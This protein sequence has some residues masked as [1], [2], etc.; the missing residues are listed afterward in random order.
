[1]NYLTKK[2][3]DRIYKEI[4]SDINEDIIFKAYKLANCFLS[5]AFRSIFRLPQSYESAE[6]EVYQPGDSPER[7]LW[8]RIN[9]YQAKNL[10]LSISQNE[11][12]AKRFY[13]ESEYELVLLIDVSRSM[14]LKW[15]KIYESNLVKGKIG[16][17]YNNIILPYLKNSKIYTLKLLTT[18]FLIAAK[19]NNFISK[20]IMFGGQGSPVEFS[21]QNELEL[22]KTIIRQIDNHFFKLAVNNLNEP[23]RLPSVLKEQCNYYKKRIIMCISDFLDGIIHIG[24]KEPRMNIN[25][26]IQYIAE[27]SYRYRFL[28]IRINDFREIMHDHDSHPEELFADKPYID[29]EEYPEK[30][31]KFAIYPGH[32]K[33]FVKNAND[34]YCNF[35]NNLRKTGAFSCN[36][37][38]G[39]NINDLLNQITTY[40]FVY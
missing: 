33:L 19:Q 12:L 34:W 29:V 6:P 39:E 17:N 20:I 28:I 11:I 3:P 4:L 31:I 35:E 27:L 40:Q 26:I 10:A 25:D 7:I 8:S 15:W 30:A 13:K 1:M 36:I 16:T 23:V 18:S 14:M 5:G 2:I 32:R 38:A 9:S 37:V 24:S 21:T 22:E